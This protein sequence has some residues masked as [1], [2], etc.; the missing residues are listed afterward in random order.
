MSIAEWGPRGFAQTIPRS[1]RPRIIRSQPRFGLL[2]FLRQKLFRGK[3][4][5]LNRERYVIGNGSNKVFLVAQVDSKDEVEFVF[6][7]YPD[8]LEFED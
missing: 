5:T 3:L 1:W 7:T 4:S 2:S 8:A 6:R